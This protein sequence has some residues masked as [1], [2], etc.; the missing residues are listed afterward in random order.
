MP[1]VVAELSKCSRY[2]RNP[3]FG[4]PVHD[5]PHSRVVELAEQV[6]VD[7]RRETLAEVDRATQQQLKPLGWVG[8]RR[9]FRQPGR[10]V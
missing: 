1:A 9:E 8:D 7:R 4:D 10:A 2:Q 6:H 3:V 5:R